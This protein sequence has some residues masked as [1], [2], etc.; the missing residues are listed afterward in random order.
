MTMPS[1]LGLLSIQQQCKQLRLPAMAGQCGPLAQVAER[2]R[3]TYLGYP[4]RC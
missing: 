2:E 1:D 4:K 3:H